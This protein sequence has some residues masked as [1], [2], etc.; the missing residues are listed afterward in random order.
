VDNEQLNV[1]AFS[2]EIQASTR[3]HLER[4]ALVSLFRE[5]CTDLNGAQVFLPAHEPINSP[6]MQKHLLPVESRQ[7]TAKFVQDFT[8]VVG[9][10]GCNFGM[11][12]SQLEATA[13]DRS[14][15]RVVCLVSASDLQHGRF[16]LPLSQ[17]RFNSFSS[18]RSEMVRQPSPYEF[19][20]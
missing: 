18:A 12:D 15:N 2:S 5:H 6:A 16:V 7:Q 13:R 10:A 19:I 17:I 1:G 11:F 14:G 3:I 9:S 8:L 20:D 4:Q